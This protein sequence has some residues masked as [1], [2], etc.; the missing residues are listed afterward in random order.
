MSTIS[1]KFFIQVLEDGSTLH[2]QLLANPTPTQ[3]YKD[4]TFI[5]NWETNAASRPIIYLSLQN[6]A[7]DIT[8]DNGYTWSYN[9]SVITFS[10]ET[11]TQTIGGTTYTGYVSTGDTAEKFFKTTYN[12][13]P[14]LGIIGNLA[15]S[16]NV[17]IDVIRFDGQKTLSTNPI[18]FS[19][20]INITITQWTSGGYLGV[21]NFPNGNIITAKEQTLT[22][23]AIL[24][25][26]NGVVNNPQ[27]EWYYEGDSQVKGTQSSFTINESDITDYA[28]L[29]CDFYMTINGTRTKV[30]SAYGSIDDQQDP[31]FM[32][33]KYNGANGN[34]VSLRQNESVAFN[35]CAGTADNSNPITTGEPA[36]PL[37]TNF[38]VKFLDSEGLLVTSTETEHNDSAFKITP[39]S[40]G[41][42]T[43][44]V[45]NGVATSKV[46]CDDVV[47]LCKKGLTGYVVAST[48]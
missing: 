46:Y 32:W 48:N 41:Y 11:S 2:G 34:S 40:N 24:Y 22:C 13:K 29:R 19:A 38:K 18:D 43:L 23:T 30:Y 20:T 37:Y 27:Y 6:G 17:D 45:S 21:L 4:G 10:S 31:E 9:G 47:G 1:N 26:D 3:S 7:S 44:P 36:T 39:D 15:S 8:P 33:I 35:I 16:Q 28:V 42:R 14:A 5:P 25:N 12:G